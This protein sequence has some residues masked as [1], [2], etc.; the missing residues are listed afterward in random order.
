[1]RGSWICAAGREAGCVVRPTL[2]AAGALYGGLSRSIAFNRSSSCC[3]LASSAL[4]VWIW[5][6]SAAISRVRASTLLS[7]FELRLRLLEVDLSVAQRH[8]QLRDPLL[9]PID[10]ID[11]GQ[12]LTL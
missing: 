2:L 9:P 7:V 12:N 10:L 4:T 1:M 8:S 11:Q 6:R 3:R 5:S